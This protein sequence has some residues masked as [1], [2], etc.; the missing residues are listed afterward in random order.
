MMLI[1]G[2]VSSLETHLLANKGDP[3]FAR[4]KV[5]TPLRLC[6]CGRPRRP[7]SV[8][9]RGVRPRL[10]VQAVMDDLS[11]EVG[12]LMGTREPPACVPAQL[13]RAHAFAFRASIFARK[14]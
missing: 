6:R 2:A 10:H 13:P 7:D 9:K 8:A 14:C 4:R 12:I 11:L 1:N 5:R 3:R